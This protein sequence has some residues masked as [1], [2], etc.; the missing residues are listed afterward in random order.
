MDF[1]AMFEK[2][3]KTSWYEELGNLDLVPDTEGVANIYW[4]LAGK[5]ETLDNYDKD[6]WI[7]AYYLSRQE[8]NGVIVEHTATVLT[9]EEFKVWL[10]ENLRGTEWDNLVNQIA[11]A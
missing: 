11:N 8:I 4:L 2:L 5:P 1:K 7:K 6:L 10:S 3:S 9:P